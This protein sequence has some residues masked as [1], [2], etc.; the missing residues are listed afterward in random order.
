MSSPYIADATNWRLAINEKADSVIYMMPPPKKNVY[1]QLRQTYRMIFTALVMKY[2]TKWHL[3][4]NF[5]KNLS[6]FQIMFKN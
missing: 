6:Y 4:T 2:Q 5:L 1:G 3:Y